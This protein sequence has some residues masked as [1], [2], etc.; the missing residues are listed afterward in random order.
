MLSKHPLSK[1]SICSASAFEAALSKMRLRLDAVESDA[2]EADASI[3]IDDEAAS[4]STTK[5]M[6]AFEAETLFGA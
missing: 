1:Q 6:L 5:R 2:F 3:R 4:A